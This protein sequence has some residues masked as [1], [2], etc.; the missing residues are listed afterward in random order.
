MVRGL[1]QLRAVWAVKKR[2]PIVPMQPWPVWAIKKQLPKLLMFLG[3]MGTLAGFALPMG[4][5]L[6]ARGFVGL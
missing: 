6:F 1:D 5:C 4:K 2:L 3:I